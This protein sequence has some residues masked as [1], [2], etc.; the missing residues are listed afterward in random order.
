MA[1]SFSRAAKLE[2]L[3]LNALTATSW[4]VVY[5]RRQY[6]SHAHSTESRILHNP[7]VACFTG[8]GGDGCTADAGAPKG[9][10]TENCH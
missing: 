3:S 10:D 8:I 5:F 4:A 9:D 2:T 7:M 6:E 1:L